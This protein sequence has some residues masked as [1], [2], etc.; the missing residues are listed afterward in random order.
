M[1]HVSGKL[2]HL[3]INVTP[4]GL[5]FYQ[6]LFTFLGWDP[7]VSGDGM[8][9]FMSEGGASLWFLAIANGATNDRDGTG[10]NHIA[11]DADSQAE[12]DATASW[13]R[14][15]GIDALHDTPCH[16]PDFAQSENDT[17]YQVM[18][19]S[20]DGIQFEH[21]YIGPKQD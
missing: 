14:D 5:P 11:I 20:P 17:Y 19:A 8:T 15:K 10:V 3:Q 2:S 18:F 7:F 1:L 6:E 4:A 9:S 13:L 12:V 21:V 16:R